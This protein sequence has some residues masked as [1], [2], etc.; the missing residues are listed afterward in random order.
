MSTP[1][2]VARLGIGADGAAMLE[3][4]QDS[5][6]LLENAM[7]LVVADVGIE[8]DAAGIVVAGGVVEPKGLGQ[9]E[10]AV[11]G[12]GRSGHASGLLTSIL[13]WRSSKRPKPRQS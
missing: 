8:A 6:A 4:S 11:P 12:V 9:A 10:W 2:A 3:V 1:A 7:A 5:Q 13:A